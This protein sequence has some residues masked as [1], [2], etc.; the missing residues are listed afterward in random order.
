MILYF[1]GTGNSRYCAQLLARKLNDVCTDSF[2]A[3]RD[4]IAAEFSSE[5]PW[6]FVSPTYS[7]QIP[8]VFA[9]LIANGRFS[10]SREAYFVMTCGSDIGNAAAANR[11]LCR[12]K[13][14]HY[15][16]T[17]PVVMPENYIAMFD[18]PERQEA[19]GIVAAAGP[20]VEQAAAWIQAGE[21]F[22]AQRVS[23]LDH[24]KS[25]I[26][27]RL[28]YR[29]QVKAGPF[30]V[31]NSCISC[32]KCERVCPMGNIRLEGGKPVWGRRCTHCMACI[33]GCPA[34]AIEYGRISQGKP[35]Y[36]CPVDDIQ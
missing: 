2:H 22:P 15:R 33:C 13:G 27:N 11:A 23:A 36:Q 34:K 20:V 32:G 8:R 16:G 4:G 12:E 18:A 28:F 25:G 19:L 7:W 30:T 35:R 17:L 31:S 14:L 21:D 9:G 5:K 1:T 6:V 10:G 26:V 3:I 24:L 29:F